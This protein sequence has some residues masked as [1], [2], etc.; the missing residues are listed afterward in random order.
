MEDAV[1]KGAKVTIGGKKP[2]LP[3]PYNKVGLVLQRCWLHQALAALM[4]LLQSCHT[5]P[6][7]ELARCSVACTNALCVAARD[8]SMR[9]QSSQGQRQT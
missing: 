7:F 8:P 9:R 3:E 2:D 1:S 4:Y 5:F 6:H